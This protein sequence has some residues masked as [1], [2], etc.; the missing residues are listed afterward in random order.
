MGQDPFTIANMNGYIQSNITNTLF[1]PIMAPALIK[2]PLFLAYEC[3]NLFGD[4]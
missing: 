4:T 2:A 1:V 3:I